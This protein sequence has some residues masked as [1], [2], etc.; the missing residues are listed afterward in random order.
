VGKGKEQSL[1]SGFDDTGIIKCGGVISKVD[2][3]RSDERSGLDA[4]SELEAGRA[5]DA[6]AGRMIRS[7]MEMLSCRHQLSVVLTAGADWLECRVRSGPCTSHMG[8]ASTY[9]KLPPAGRDQVRA[10]RALN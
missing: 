7:V 4:R 2:D 10:E 8:R 6:E 5:A 3:E 9:P 1:G